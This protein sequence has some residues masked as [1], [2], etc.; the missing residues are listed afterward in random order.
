VPTIAGIWQAD[1]DKV[2]VNH[3]SQLA[4]IAKGFDIPR[5]GNGECFLALGHP[6][7]SV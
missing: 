7:T 4:T 3:D 6:T 2:S 5:L 1:E